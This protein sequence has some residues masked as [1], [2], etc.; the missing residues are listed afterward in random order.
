MKNKICIL[1]IF[2]FSTLFSNTYSD[3]FTPHYSSILEEKILT[4]WQNDSTLTVDLVTAWLVAEGI[5]DTNQINQ[6]ENLITSLV[7]DLKSKIRAKDK[8]NKKGETIFKYLHKRVFKINKEKAKL[9]QVFTTGE[10]NCLTGSC[11]YYHICQ[12]F[13]IPAHI[14]LSPLHVYSVIQDKQKKIIVE[15]TEPKKGYNFKIDKKK[16]LKYF[17]EYKLVP[18]DEYDQKGADYIYDQY[19]S[20]SHQ[21]DPAL[22]IG[23]VYSN[24][25]LAFLQEND[26]ENAV[27]NMEKALMID[28][29]NEIFQNNYKLTIEVFGDSY[30][31]IEKFLPF[32]K[33]SLYLLNG[34]R[35]FLESSISLARNGIF[36]FCDDKRDFKSSLDLIHSFR[37][38]VNNEKFLLAIQDFEKSVR[39][40]EAITYQNRGNYEK[41][42]NSFSSLYHAD[43]NDIKTKDALVDVGIFYA[44]RLVEQD[45]NYDKANSIM[46]S[47]YSKCP[48]YPS[49]K[50][51]YT[52][53]LMAPIY[54]DISV[55]NSQEKTL[56]IALKAYDFNPEH[57]RVQ[58]QI[59]KIYHDKA[60]KK[61]RE[62]KTEEA[63]K[64]ISKGL[65][66][67]PK[68]VTLLEELRM[69]DEQLK[70]RKFSK[71][72]IK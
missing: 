28:R 5:S 20:S 1:L 17:L 14:F 59:A 46:D 38:I 23:G 37:N 33:N 54:F 27:I 67:A 61:I 24:C 62:N 35:L 49:V 69:I 70:K 36:Y 12:V 26:L 58:M 41:A 10:F 57:P 22:L 11:L 71:Y 72:H 34:D 52:G 64:L 44:K 31:E 50:E 60:M 56:K 13:Q 32:F 30:Y 53:T 42:F 66:Y 25:G 40:E 9:N 39:Y 55:K 8:V 2:I 45:Q 63:K 6:I 7:E 43:K 4:S 68:N 21:I 65:I 18:Q 29:E 3:K 15:I 47:L 48:D 51:T 19:I 16:I